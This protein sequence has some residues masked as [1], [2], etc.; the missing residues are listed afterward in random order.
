VL[1]GKTIVALLM[2][3]VLR[4]DEM[5][6]GRQLSPE[7]RHKMR[8]MIRHQL[9]AKLDPRDR[10][11]LAQ[12]EDKYIFEIDKLKEVGIE[13]GFAE[14]EFLNRG[15]VIHTYWPYLETTLRTTGIPLEHIQAYRWIGAEFAETYGLMFSDKLATPMGY[16]VFRKSPAGARTAS[17]AIP[18]SARVVRSR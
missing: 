17:E 18:T 14:V 8:L 5:T 12:I 13:A 10:D 6:D 4:C 9:K 16:F 7:D 2:A 1:E 11:A 15:D 3:L